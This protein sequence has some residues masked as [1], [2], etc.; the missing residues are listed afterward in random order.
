MNRFFYFIPAVLFFVSVLFLMP[1]Q[2]HPPKD[3]QCSYDLSAKKLTVTITH[4]SPFPSSHYVGIV[5]IK[6]NGVSV[7]RNTYTSQPDQSPF[8]YTYTIDAAK[9]DTL[10]VEAVCNIFGSKTADYKVPK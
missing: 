10:S 1:A 6:K 8:S 2:A 9:G 3:V 7:S 5:E 4:S